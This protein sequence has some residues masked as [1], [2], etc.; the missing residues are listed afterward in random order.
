M[1]PERHPCP[2]DGRPARLVQMLPTFDVY[3]CGCGAK[4]QI[5]RL[6]KKPECVICGDTGKVSD[7]DACPHCEDRFLSNML[8]H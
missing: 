6:D 1:S 3:H 4:F 5:T 2:V 8:R 7:G